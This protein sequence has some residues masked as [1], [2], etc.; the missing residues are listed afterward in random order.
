VPSSTENLQRLV[1]AVQVGAA[2]VT[3]TLRPRSP[4]GERKR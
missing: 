1:P 2:A 3:R 4:L